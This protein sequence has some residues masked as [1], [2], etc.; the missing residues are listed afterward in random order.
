MITNQLGKILFP[1]R[2]RWE[3]ERE[4][5]ALLVAT[6]VA[7]IVAGVIGLVIVWRNNY[8]KY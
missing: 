7:L 4:V 3:R 1:R 5:R 6:L 8:G 2:Q